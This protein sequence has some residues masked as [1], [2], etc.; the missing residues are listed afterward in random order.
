MKIKNKNIAILGGSFDPVHNGHLAIAALALEHLNLQEIFFIP[1][2]TPPHKIDSVNCSAEVRLD[3][4]IKAT[5]SDDRFTVWDGEILR[6]G[7]SYTLDTICEFEK[8]YPDSKLFF[9]IGSDNIEEILTWNRWEQL[10]KKVTFAVTLRPGYTLDIPKKLSNANFIEFPSP[11]WGLS[12]SAIREYLKKGHSCSYL[13]PP[14][15]QKTVIQ[16]KLYR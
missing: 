16:N 5:A 2:G 1:A 12:S 15:V 10:I 13:L 6:N 11:M 3:M 9:I 8:L 14:T 4:L 7:P